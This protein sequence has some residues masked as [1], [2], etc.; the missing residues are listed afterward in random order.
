M[1]LLGSDHGFLEVEPHDPAAR[2]A[3]REVVLLLHGLGGNKSE[4]SFPAWR[5]YHW[6]HAGNPEER[7]SDNHL[8]PPLSPWELIP[9][10]S[11]SDLREDV[12]CWSGILKAL[13]HTIINYSQ[14]GPQEVVDV[15]LAQLEERIAPFVRDEVLTGTLAGK[16]V[17]LLC[18][19]RGGI[20]ARA[21]LRRHPEAAEW[22]GRVITLC[23]PHQGTLA[24][25][26]KQRLMDAAAVL[27][28]LS[29]LPLISGLNRITGLI[30]ESAGAQQ[31][32]PDDPI[33]DDLALPA[34]LPDIQFFTFGGTSVRYFRIYSWHYTPDSYVPNFGDFP[35]IRFDWTQFPI[36]VPFA[37][38]VMEC[39][40]DLIVEDE[41]DEGEG[42]GLV[43]DERA[44]L[45]GAT[46]VSLP[47]SH[48]EAL[49]DEAPFAQVAELLGTPLTGSEMVECVRGFIANLRTRQ[50]HDPLRKRRACQL[51]EILEPWPFTRA[52]DAFE[53]GFDGCA[54]C[55]P[56]HHSG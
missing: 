15:P 9:E 12:P 7:E 42:D 26:A 50:L 21:Y 54:F 4:W 35:D 37:S 38:P 5:S 45:P 10:F 17:T 52:E 36:E 16:R 24:P 51:D 31:L 30:A 49:W 48:A 40:P 6:N 41:Q 2:R 43:S 39:L 13:G 56:E 25:N 19:S 8:L 53:Q 44:R 34:E 47:I 33:F 11:L 18:H 20:L 29:V 3:D 14:D 23:S 1:T 22:I 55:M 27:D 46:H 32:L 28:P